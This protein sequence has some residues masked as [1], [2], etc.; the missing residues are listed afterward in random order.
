M[1]ATTGTKR[2]SGGNSCGLSPLV[3]VRRRRMSPGWRCS[4]ANICSNGGTRCSSGYQAEGCLAR[5]AA[6]KQKR[7][8]LE[9]RYP[10]KRSEGLRKDLRLEQL[11]KR[12]MKCVKT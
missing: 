3:S 1:S 8:K 11:L 12:G 5:V 4:S 2:T 7:F 9:T 10:H 6:Q